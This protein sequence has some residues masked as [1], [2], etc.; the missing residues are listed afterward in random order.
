MVAELCEDHKTRS[1][2]ISRRLPNEEEYEDS[3][4][5]KHH[6]LEGQIKEVLSHVLSK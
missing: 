6:L 2:K 5:E 3:I 1:Y 4:I